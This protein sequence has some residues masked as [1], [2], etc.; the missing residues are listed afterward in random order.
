[1]AVRHAGRRTRCHLL[2][3]R[4]VAVVVVVGWGSLPPHFFGHTVSIP[5]SPK[6]CPDRTLVISILDF[7]PGAQNGVR[8]L[9]IALINAI[10]PRQIGQKRGLCRL[11]CYTKIRLNGLEI[12]APSGYEV[13]LALNLTLA[14]KLA[15]TPVL[16][17]VC[18]MSDG[19][20]H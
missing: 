3:G 7:F 12:C 4:V 14:L 6:H 17:L 1:M 19:T 8:R 18:R 15:L 16:C 9:V 13:V 2:C 5:F 20:G 11:T 10:G